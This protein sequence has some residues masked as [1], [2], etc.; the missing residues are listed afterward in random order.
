MV[1]RPLV[2]IIAI[3]LFS[4]PAP[5]PAA[6]AAVAAPAWVLHQQEPS[7]TTKPGETG[8][9]L[10]PGRTLSYTATEGTWM[11]LDVSPDGQ[12]II[13]DLL[14]DIYT[15]PIEGGKATRITSGM[16]YDVQPRFSPDGQ[17]IVFVSDRSGAENLWLMAADGSDTVQ[18]TKG[19]N[20]DF[21]SPEWTPDGTYIV[22]SKGRNAKLWLYHVDGG[23]GV[24]LIG[25]SSNLHMAGAAFGNDERYI[26]Y[27]RRNGRH[28]Y[29]AAFPLYQLAVYDRESGESSTMTSRYGSAVRPTLSPDGKWLVYGTRHSGETGL[30]IRDLASGEERWLAYPVQR[31]DQESTAPMDALPGFSFTPDSRSIVASYGGKFWRV[32]VEGEGRQWEIPFSADVEVGI[33]PRVRFEYAVESSPTF[34]ARQVRDAKP[35]PDGT[36]LAFVV[37]DRLYVMD[38]PKG[39]PRRL[40]DM[41]VGQYQP[42]WSPD[43]EWIGFVTWNDAE[44]GHVY[45]TRANGRGNPERLTEIAAFFRDP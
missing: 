11:S 30:R 44:G 41:D 4:I 12:T 15:M 45:K 13:F 34:I 14:G 40:A 19:T 20:D 7:D 36:R 26:W 35:S 27:A 18:V 31:D 5:A 38:Y 9:P 39:T 24:A 6:A 17:R 22:A 43:G 28:Q 16:A 10:E 29:N 21:L 8:L 25:D 37:L 1:R 23:S 42:T 2:G 3:I 32:S 33:G